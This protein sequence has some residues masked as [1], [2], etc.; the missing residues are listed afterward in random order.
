MALAAQ[1]LKDTFP[2]C[3][4]SAATDLGL[5]VCPVTRTRQRCA[6]LGAGEAGRQG[7]AQAP[8]TS[9]ELRQV[10]IYQVLPVGLQDSRLL[11]RNHRHS[12]VFP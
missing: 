1:Q 6:A 5:P 8:R 4:P 12:R 7:L 2:C 11:Q 3:L 10:S 9:G